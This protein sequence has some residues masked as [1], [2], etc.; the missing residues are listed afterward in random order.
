MNSSLIDLLS[1]VTMVDFMW[2]ACLIVMLILIFNS[3]KQ[4]IT[5]KLDEWRKNKNKKENFTQL[6][7]TLKDSVS[8]LKS[9]MDQYQENR[10]HDREDSRK[11]R[12]EM[13]QVMNTQS[14]GID[15]LTKIIVAMQEKNSKTKRAEIKEKIERLYRECHPSMVCTDMALETLK[16]LI[17]EYEAHGGLNSFVHSTVEPEMYEWKVIKTIKE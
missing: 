10:E 1:K 8:D 15:N 12:D 5:A 16:E 6:V 2:A 9:T 11:I 14:E 3:Q 13:Y 4:K 17:K 7:Y